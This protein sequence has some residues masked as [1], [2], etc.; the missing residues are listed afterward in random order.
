MKC[1]PFREINELKSGFDTFTEAYAEILQSGNVPRSLE[2]DIFRLQQHQSSS[3]AVE[4][5]E[6]CIHVL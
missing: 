6:V 2:Q 4:D 5:E 1:K 3:V